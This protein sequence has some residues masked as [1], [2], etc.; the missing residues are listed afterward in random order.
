M[1]ENLLI[2][3][4]VVIIGLVIATAILMNI[5][6]ATTIVEVALVGVWIYL[7]WIVRKKKAKIFHD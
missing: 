5:L 2:G 7:V 3:I 1:K 4:I 6:W